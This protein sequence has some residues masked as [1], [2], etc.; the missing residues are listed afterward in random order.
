MFKESHDHHIELEET[1]EDSPTESGKQHSIDLAYVLDESLKIV[2][3]TWP[4][5]GSVAVNPFWNK[6]DRE[7]EKALSFL[8]NSMGCRLLPSLSEYQSKIADRSISVANINK[9]LYDHHQ[10]PCDVELFLE[11]LK[12]CKNDDQITSHSNAVEFKFGKKF[13]QI[14]LQDLCKHLMTYFD[15]RQ[16]YLKPKD[17][18]AS[19]LSFWLNSQK[20]DRSIECL[21]IPRF[22]TSAS[23]F[24][25][26]TAALSVDTE[27][28]IIKNS[29][30]I[31][32]GI[33]DW[34][35]QKSIDLK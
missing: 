12:M 15:K 1:L 2:M 18:P 16:A 5:Q 32:V 6:K 11:K 4:L 13:D 23:L 27:Q 35:F 25:N 17:H 8:E 31:Y 28:S 34:N 10:K 21:G 9:A 20:Y 30:E 29:I 19:F 33:K 14:I 22:N 26:M 7:F 24:K 3:P